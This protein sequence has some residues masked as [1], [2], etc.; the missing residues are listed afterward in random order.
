MY[1][2]Q[3]Q[4]LRW[5]R[6]RFFGRIGFALAAGAFF[7]WVAYEP[8]PTADAPTAIDQAD[9]R[10][11]LRNARFEDPGRT[12]WQEARTA[13]IDPYRLQPTRTVS[14]ASA[15]QTRATDAQPTAAASQDGAAPNVATAAP[16]S[17][18]PPQ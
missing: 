6:L 14:S 4:D 18:S 7:A 13:V 15:P 8:T 16:N 5:R 3:F 1:T 12:A 9:S 10:I 17:R 2:H 11:N